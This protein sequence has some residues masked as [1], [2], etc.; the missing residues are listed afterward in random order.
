MVLSFVLN[1]IDVTFNSGLHEQLF[2]QFWT[3]LRV[4]PI[5]GPNH[6][7]LLKLFSHLMPLN[8]L[9]CQIIEINPKH[10]RKCTLILT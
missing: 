10:A 6:A 5:S 3:C 2:K 1:T 9:I 8:I 4:L 7:H